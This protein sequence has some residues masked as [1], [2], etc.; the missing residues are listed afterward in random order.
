M[1]ILVPPA[2]PSLLPHPELRV[3]LQIS[4]LVKVSL[5]RRAAGFRDVDVNQF[6]RRIDRHD[7]AALGRSA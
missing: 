6:V 4:D 5:D 2:I 1:L 7:Q 3:P